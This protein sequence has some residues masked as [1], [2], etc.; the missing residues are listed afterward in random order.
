MRRSG[1]VPVLAIGLALAAAALGWL[2]LRG[3]P[4]VAPPTDRPAAPVANRLTVHL[5][6]DGR[7]LL[8]TP[9]QLVTRLPA[10]GREDLLA[11]SDALHVYARAVEARFPARDFDLGG[12]RDGAEL[13]IRA[14]PGASWESVTWLLYAAGRPALRIPTVHLEPVGAP[15]VTVPIP[16][17]RGHTDAYVMDPTHVH[18]SPAGV[19]VYDGGVIAE[20]GHVFVDPDESPARRYR[21]ASLARD[22]IAGLEQAIRGAFGRQAWAEG[23]VALTWAQDAGLPFG[24]MA[25]ILAR[26]MSAGTGILF[27]AGLDADEIHGR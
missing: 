8:G 11:W 10:A 18:V 12:V 19:S 1:V 3:Q 5:A 6:S 4:P 21:S 23:I 17:D 20:V 7:V 24:R 16:H 27:I 15:A 2:W 22:D 14:R 13:T 9:G 25:D 26:V